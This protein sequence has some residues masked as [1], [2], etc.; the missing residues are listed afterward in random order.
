[1]PISKQ[2]II[3]EAVAAFFQDGIGVQ[4]LSVD[5]VFDVAA[6]VSG[7][8]LFKEDEFADDFMDEELEMLPP[9]LQTR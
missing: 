9:G 3:Q 8:Q 7:K 5:F 4:E 6:D 2:D 1:M